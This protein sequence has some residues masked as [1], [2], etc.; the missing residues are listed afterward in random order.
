MINNEK[1]SKTKIR[2]ILNRDVFW[3]A[4]TAIENGLIDEEWKNNI[5]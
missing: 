4:K 3:D 2:E 5:D 1:L